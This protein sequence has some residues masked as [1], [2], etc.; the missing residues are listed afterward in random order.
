ME[1]KTL[2]LQERIAQNACLPVA[3]SAIL[4]ILPVKLCAG[5]YHMQ[6]ESVKSY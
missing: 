1:L 5:M 4:P 3:C 6:E 2:V